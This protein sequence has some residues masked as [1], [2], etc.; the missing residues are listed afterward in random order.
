MFR[1]IRLAPIK[2][3]R[4]FP[5]LF[6]TALEKRLFSNGADRST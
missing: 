2:S 5:A 1:N 6:A 3:R 4:Y